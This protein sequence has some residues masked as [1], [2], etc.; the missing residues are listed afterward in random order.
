MVKADATLALED[1]EVV[2]FHP[3]CGMDV[4]A[5]Q[6]IVLDAHPHIFDDC[7]ERPAFDDGQGNVLTLD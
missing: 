3:S 7:E 2:V 6:D 4:Q 5:I 1:D